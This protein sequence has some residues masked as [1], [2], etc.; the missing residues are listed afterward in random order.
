[1]V[2]CYCF[3]IISFPKQ[4]HGPTICVFISTTNFGL[5]TILDVK[6][7]L[8][9]SNKISRSET[10]CFIFRTY[11]SVL[12]L[13]SKSEKLNRTEFKLTYSYAETNIQ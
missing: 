1:M 7:K 10:K 11:T 2:L 13:K 5:Q 12:K 6:Q 9:F 3:L 4:S 8:Y